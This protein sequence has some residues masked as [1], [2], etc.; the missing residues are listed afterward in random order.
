MEPEYITLFLG[1]QQA[2]WIWQFY[3]QLGFPLKSPIVIYSDSQAAINVTKAEHTHK[4]SKHLDIKLHSIRERIQGGQIEV[5]Y[6]PTKD[7]LADIFTK[8]LGRN[9]FQDHVASLGIEGGEN[10]EEVEEDSLETPSRYE[11]ALEG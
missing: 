8:S 10:V 9:L 11:D 5:R 4:L 7:N 3:D 6:V 2:A 1:A